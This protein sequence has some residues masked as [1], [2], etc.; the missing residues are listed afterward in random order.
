M[1]EYF[2]YKKMR[3]NAEREKKWCKF[4]KLIKA[5][6]DAE[7]VLFAVPR[8]FPIEKLNEMK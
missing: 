8:G 3:C 1:D 7:I 2:D 4:S 6:P 5:D